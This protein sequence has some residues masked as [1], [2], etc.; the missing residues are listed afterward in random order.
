MVDIHF[1]GLQ[2]TRSVQQKNQ[3][4]IYMLQKLPVQN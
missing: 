3:L 4:I 1:C 2:H